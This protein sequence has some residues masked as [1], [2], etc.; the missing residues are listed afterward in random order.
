MNFEKPNIIPE[1]NR[2][3]W[4]EEGFKYFKGELH[5]HSTYSNRQEMGGGKEDMVHSETRLLSYAEK[6]GLDFLYFSEHSSDPGNPQELEEDHPICQSLLKQQ[7]KINEINKSNKYKIK[8]Y[9]A[10]EANMLFNNEEKAVIDVP[11]S[12]LNKMDLVVASRHRTNL[13]TTPENIKK[14]FL[15][16]ANNKEVDIIGH[17]YRYIEFYENDWRYFKK[18]FK[19]KEIGP[20]LQEL[21]DKGDWDSIKQIIGKNEIKDEKMREYNALFNNLK[22]DYWDAWSEILQTMEDNNKGFEINLSSFD[23]NKEYFRTLLKKTTDYKKLKYSIVF[24]F[25]NFDQLERYDVKNNKNN[26][27][28]GIKNP[29]RSKGVSRLLELIDLLKELKIGP[30]R[31][32]NSSQENMEKF[33]EERNK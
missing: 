12:I 18:C 25:H 28:E 31:I 6:L 3:D 26:N 23:P 16:A 14:I 2:E 7:E 21:E 10:V 30:E 22:K 15:A 13:P 24:D 4:K 20:K 27:P 9:Q 1:R 8:A 33:L 29:A 19:N 5:T 11:N 32:I 17:P